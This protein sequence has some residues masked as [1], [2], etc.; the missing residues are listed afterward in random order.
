MVYLRMFRKSI[1]NLR[2]IIYQK[3][4]K[5]LYIPNGEFMFSV[6]G[7]HNDYD[8]VFQCYKISY[9]FLNKIMVITNK[10]INV[11]IRCYIFNMIKGIFFATY[12]WD[13]QFVL[14]SF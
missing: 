3:Y 11:K 6:V 12:N 10:T 1:N 7:L 8:S 13:M 14:A 5:R 2:I 9:I 4:C